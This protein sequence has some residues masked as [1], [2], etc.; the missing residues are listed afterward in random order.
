VPAGSYSLT[1]IAYDN[2]GAKTTS[3]ARSITV[4]AAPTTGPPTKVV[5]QA[6]VDNAMVTSY[7]LDIFANGA[8]P[9]TATPVATSNLGKPAVDANGDI[10]VDQATLFSGLAAG[11][12]QATV[13]AIGS[14]GSSRST[15][16]TFTR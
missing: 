2:A 1:A 15:A 13:S 11:T 16:V 3:A 14:G 8:N 7:Q 10:T 6:S 12:Y 9:S 5:F 4:N